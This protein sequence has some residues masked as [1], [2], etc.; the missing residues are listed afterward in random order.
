MIHPPVYIYALVDPETE[1]IRYIGKSI[2]P[3]ERLTNHMNDRGNCHRTHWLAQLKAKG[4]KPKL[5]IFE[6]V[7]AKDDWRVVERAWIAIAERYQW[8]ITNSTTGGDGVEGLPEET[9][10][11]MRQVWLGRKHKP[12]SLAKIGAASSGR[13]HTAEY[14][15]M[16][17]SKMLGRKLSRDTRHKISQN[18]SKL[19]AEQAQ[20][21]R[22][23]LAQGEKQYVVAQRF[24]VHKSTISNIKRGKFYID[25]AIIERERPVLLEVAA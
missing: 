18:V 7:K 5:V 1:E 14:K 4:L 13:T 23:L 15:A 6:K 24:G 3:K 21:V 10:E 16:M 2:R 12:E 17:R 22:K 20:E 9:R 11:R 8:P 25:Q 19:T